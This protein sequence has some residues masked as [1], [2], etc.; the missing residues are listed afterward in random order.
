[1]PKATIVQQLDRS[2]AA[3]FP[4]VLDEEAEHRTQL[5]ATERILATDRRE[6]H[7]HEL[8]VGR[9]G[10]PRLASDRLWLLTH[11]VRID[12]FARGRDH[13]ALEC[14]LLV[15]RAEVCA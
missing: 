2:F 9:D 3:A 13:Q 14:A 4:P 1:M 6:I 12:A 10:E 15:G 7:D 8:R 5:L 11:D